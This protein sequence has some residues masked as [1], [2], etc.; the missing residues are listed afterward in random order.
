MQ[1]KPPYLLSFFLLA[2]LFAL[3]TRAI[4]AEPEPAAVVPRPA[5]LDWKKWQKGQVQLDSH[6]RII[7]A[8]P[9]PQS[10]AEMM[11]SLLRSAT[12]LPFP[13]EELRAAV[14][15]SGN[16]VVLR[17]FPELERGLGKEGYS[18]DVE[19]IPP[20]AVGFETIQITA[21]APAGL[22]YGGQTLR[23]LL[24]AADVAKPKQAGV[25]WQVPCCHIE[26]RP[27]FPWRG[28][29]LDES[30]HFFG[31]EFVKQCIDLLAAYKL[32]TL[33][34]HLTDDQGWRI[35]I[36]K[37]PKL[38]EIGA[39]RDQ[40]EARRQALRRFLHPGRNPRGRRLRRPAARDHRARNRDARPFGRCAGLLSA[41]LLPGGAAQGP[42]RL[43][44]AAGCF[45]P[46]QRCHVRLPR[47]RA[48]RSRGSL[49][50]DF[51]PRRRR[52][53]SQGPLEKM[54]Q[55]PG[56]HQGRG[57]EGRRRIA[58]LLHSPDRRASGL[59]GA[60][61]DRLGRDPRR[62]PGAQGHGDELARHGRRDRRGQVGSRLCRHA[63]FALLLRLPPQ[64]DQLGKGLCLR[65]DPGKAD[66]R[67]A[68]TLSRRAGEHVDRANAR[69]GRRRPPD[70]APLVRLGRG[71]LVS[72]GRAELCRFSRP[73]GI[74]SHA[75]G[76][77]NHG[78]RDF[79]GE[80]AGR[81]DGPGGDGRV[82]QSAVRDQAVFFLRSGF[83]HAGRSEDLVR[84]QR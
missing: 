80:P 7:Y 37:Y 60:A 84:Q 81:H 70:L 67:P 21:A 44:R 3:A 13:V 33:H 53:M 29:L 25:T 18:L 36:K 71:R 35:E 16:A 54:S 28:L 34:W 62:R 69:S 76:R 30:R 4:A 83:Y 64:R 57:T 68:G 50:L 6:T 20:T 1:P 31:K 52:R 17:L 49:P 24:A 63:H 73:H 23:Q 8:T 14:G 77:P 66:R 2:A 59:Q 12:G 10:E 75:H 51:H 19:L 27:R 82:P 15:T 48:G 55:V 79:P 72:Q 41:V 58:E 22:F 74:A 47:R 11:A 43:G 38:T 45:L 78:G 42:H 9:V 26:D 40:T 5:K 46:G 65:A 56:P 61:A 39:W 32:N